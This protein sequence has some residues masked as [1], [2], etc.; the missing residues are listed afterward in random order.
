VAVERGT[1]P[2][3]VPQKVY[4]WK[5]VYD[6]AGNGG[7]GTVTATLGTESVTLPLKGGD[8]AKGAVLDRFGLFTGHRGGSFVRIYFDDL[9]Y[10]AAR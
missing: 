2:V 1:G 7:K 6:P 10:T 3:I 5:L 4:E 9:K 8:K